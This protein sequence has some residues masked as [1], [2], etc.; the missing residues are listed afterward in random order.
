MIFGILSPPGPFL[1]PSPSP[2]IPA[3]PRL[4]PSPSQSP[5]SQQ[6][7]ILLVTNS[8]IGNVTQE[9]DRKTGV[10]GRRQSFSQQQSALVQQ[11]QVLSNSTSPNAG[12]V[13]Y[14]PSP[15][16]SPAGATTYSISTTP[17]NEFNT[18]LVGS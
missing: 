7:D 15:T 5:F 18:T 17:G 9:Q 13:V 14:R 6:Q 11:Q 12:T 3:S 8:T 1:T 4:Q 2:S 10:A 16:Q